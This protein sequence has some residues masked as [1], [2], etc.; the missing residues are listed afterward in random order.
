MVDGR[1]GRGVKRLKLKLKE[2]SIEPVAVKYWKRSMFR[3]WKRLWKEPSAVY[4][5]W[6]TRDLPFP[7]FMNTSI[8]G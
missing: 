8:V 1:K 4:A 6:E 5:F 3:P 2:R 7:P